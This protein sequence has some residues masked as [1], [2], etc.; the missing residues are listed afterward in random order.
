LSCRFAPHKTAFLLQEENSH[1][2]RNGG[3]G[4]VH[5]VTYLLFV[6][7]EGAEPDRLVEVDE[8]FATYSRHQ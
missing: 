4:V 1:M 5:L 3:R 6:W 8:Q 7:N 2:V